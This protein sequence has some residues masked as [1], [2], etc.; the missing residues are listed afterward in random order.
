MIVF[1]SEDARSIH[2]IKHVQHVSTIKSKDLLANIEC[3]FSLHVI[4][5]TLLLFL[6]EI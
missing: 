2:E 1:P 5:V 4:S 6:I 3:P